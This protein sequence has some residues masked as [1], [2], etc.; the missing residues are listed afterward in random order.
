MKIEISVLT[1]CDGCASSLAAWYSNVVRLVGVFLLL[2]PGITWPDYVIFGSFRSND[3]ANN[4]AKRLSQLFGEEITSITV[5]GDDG[6][7]YRVQSGHVDEARVRLLVRKSDASGIKYWRPQSNQGSS[8]PGMVTP[9]LVAPPGLIRPDVQAEESKELASTVSAP[10]REGKSNDVARVKPIAV[11]GHRARRQWDVDVGLQSR[12][13]AKQGIAGQGKSESSL[14]LEPSYYRT[15]QQDRQSL[16][17]TPFI[18][19]DSRDSD[20]SHFDVRELFWTRIGEDWDLHVGARRVFWGVTEFHHLIDVINQT[21]LVENI[22]GEDKLGQPMVQVSF[23]RDWGI[24]DV[25]AL[26]GFRKRSFPGEQGRLRTPL[27]VEDRAVFESGAEDL[28]TDFAVRWS[29]Q[30]GPFEVGLHHFSGTS[31]DPMFLPSMIH[32]TVA[33]LQAYYPVIDQ[34]GIDA[35]AISGDLTVKFEGMSRGGY[36]E[37]Y[38]AFNAGIEKTL[39]GVLGTPIDLGVVIEY[40]HDERGDDAI[41]T[42]FEHDVAF[43][44]RFTFN[45]FADTRALVGVVADTQNSDLIYSI[46][47]S[48][49][50]SPTWSVSLEGRVFQGGR[51]LP[52]GLHFAQM[53]APEYKSAWLQQ[54][55]Y[56]QIEFKKFF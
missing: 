2:L 31:R 9:R 22:D 38:H 47:A 44:G 55:D 18:R 50:L 11:S 3:N 16:T 52:S 14:S 43:G 37:R 33:G 12:L 29:S 25:Y 34:S 40:M 10:A 28:R 19:I 56:F 24:V 27:V 48:R 23:V 13:F 45:D 53:F 26:P 32:G 30:L 1:A 7:W 6:V 17:F 5:Q 51:S 35:L 15:W 46:E 54:D 4:W 41:N 49:Q 36:G 8:G 20:R 39:V 42:L 21:D